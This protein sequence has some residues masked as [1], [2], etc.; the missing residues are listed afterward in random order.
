M[1]AIP[2]E[3]CQSGIEGFDKLCLGGFVRNS[4]N[5][6]IGGPGSGKSI[7]LLQFLWN[8]LQKDENGLYISFEPDLLDV[9]MDCYAFGWNFPKF[10][11]Q[12]TC[13]FLKFSP[14]TQPR[15]IERQ[16]LELISKYNIRRVCV[17]PISS[18]AMS[19]EKESE[20]RQIV[21]DLCALLKRM[22]VTVLLSDEIYGD[23]SLDISAGEKF[24]RFGVVE[25]LVDGLIT[26]HSMGIGGAADRAIRIVK[27]RRT[28]HVRGPVP[29]KITDNG[30][31]VLP[32][33][34]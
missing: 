34:A 5:A 1:A 21:Y 10:E 22:K 29:M 32:E 7:F 33:E 3:R 12:G 6:I 24:S 18:F 19:L 20:I 17:D 9:A 14:S 27:M 28:N 2:I 8:G 13:K 23:S 4:V 11:Q 25:F 26:L 30:I 31:V 16:L 15:E